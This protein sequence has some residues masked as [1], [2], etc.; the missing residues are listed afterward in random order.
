[1]CAQRGVGQDE[2]NTELAEIGPAAM[3]P[4]SD[5]DRVLVLTG[6]FGCWMGCEALGPANVSPT[7]LS[8]PL[9]AALSPETSRRCPLNG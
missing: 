9:P 3:P 6:S 4:S 5:S 2:K 7:V 8:V 1:M